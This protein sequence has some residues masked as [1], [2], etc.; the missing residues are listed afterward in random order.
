M[1]PEQVDAAII[2]APVGALVRRL[3]EGLHAKAAT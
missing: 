1:P 3:A 2:F